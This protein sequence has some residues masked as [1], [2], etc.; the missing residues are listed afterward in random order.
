MSS[1]YNHPPGAILTVKD[2]TFAFLGKPVFHAYGITKPFI[3][4]LLNCR[5][6]RPYGQNTQAESL[7]MDCDVVNRVTMLN[8]LGEMSFGQIYFLGDLNIGGGYNKNYLFYDLDKAIA[9]IRKFLP[10]YEPDECILKYYNP[11]DAG[12]L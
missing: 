1:N 11:L 3:E 12:L 6:L 7:I 10:T 5:D 4:V 9:H 2:L 8:I